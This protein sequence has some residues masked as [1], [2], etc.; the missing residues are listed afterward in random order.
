[1]TDAFETSPQGVPPSRHRIVID[2]STPH[3]DTWQRVLSNAENAQRQL[4]ADQTMIEVVAYGPGLGMMLGESA[5]DPARMERMSKAAVAFAACRNTLE[6]RDLAPDALLPFVRIV[7][8]GVAELVLKQE[9]GWAYLKP[10][11]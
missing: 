10:G 5:P 9:A 11:S 7:P 2:V 6:S 3:A 8:S 4:G 1:M